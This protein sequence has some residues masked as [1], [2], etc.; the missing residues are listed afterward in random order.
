[1]ITG[2]FDSL[3]HPSRVL[4]HV[5]H[6]SGGITA[7]NHRLIAVTPSGSINLSVQG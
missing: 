3:W 1:M 7:L 4:N 5:M 6:L 2:K